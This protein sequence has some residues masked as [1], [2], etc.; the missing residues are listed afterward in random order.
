MAGETMRQVFWKTTFGCSLGGGI[1]LLF[2][3]GL[4]AA[5][6]R[7]LDVYV[8]DTYFVIVPSHLVL[9]SALLFV[10]TFFVWKVKLS[11]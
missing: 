11:H 5:S 2:L 1:L 7:S 3:A 8:R 6:L 9:L 10:A 4:L